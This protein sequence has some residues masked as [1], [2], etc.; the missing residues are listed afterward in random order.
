[1]RCWSRPQSRASTSSTALCPCRAATTITTPAP[2][3]EEG[4]PKDIRGQSGAP[5]ALEDLEDAA[6]PSGARSRTPTRLTSPRSRREILTD[7]AWHSGLLATALLL[8]QAFVPDFSPRSILGDGPG[9]IHVLKSVRMLLDDGLDT[10][11][12]VTAALR[13]W[14][15]VYVIDLIWMVWSIIIPESRHRS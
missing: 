2:A 9:L 8:A 13:F 12:F 7:V 3:P 1:M 15:V 11:S 5:E 4:A 6:S 10:T 14:F